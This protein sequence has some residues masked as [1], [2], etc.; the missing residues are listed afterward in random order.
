MSVVKSGDIKSRRGRWLAVSLLAVLVPAAA[1]FAIPARV[2]IPRA[3]EARP[4]APADLAVFSHTAHEPLRCFQCH[5][6]LFP[7][8][9]FAFTHADMDNGRFCGGCHDSRRAPAVVSYPCVSCHAP[10]K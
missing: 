2:R 1:A 9:R 8:D 5:P 7:Q 4:F 10:S 6:S 3:K